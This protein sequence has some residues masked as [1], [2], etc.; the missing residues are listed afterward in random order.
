MSKTLTTI[1]WLIFAAA[2][3]PLL[4]GIV[5]F[6]GEGFDPI[7]FGIGVGGAVQGILILAFGELLE[8]AA[9]IAR[10]VEAMRPAAAPQQALA[11]KPQWRVTGKDI[12][13]GHARSV[14]VPADDPEFAAIAAGSHGIV[15][16]ASIQPA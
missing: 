13:T 10:S 4:M 5:D 15:D 9:S 8:Y 11:T 14:V 1:G 2:A 7:L 6:D 3:I 12:D 16:V